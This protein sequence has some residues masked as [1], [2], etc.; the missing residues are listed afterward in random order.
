[1]SEEA[2]ISIGIVGLSE[3]EVEEG[4]V[5]RGLSI[6]TT[7]GIVKTLIHHDPQEPTSKA[8]V[9]VCGASGGLDGPADYMYKLLG[10]ELSPKI[11]SLRV[12]YRYPG[13]LTESVMDTLA[14][15][16]FLTGTGH[17]DILLVGHSFGGAVVI[18][19]APFSEQVKGVIALSSQTAGSH[20][21]GDV[22]PRPLLLIH[23]D[24]D[25]VLAHSCSEMIYDWAEEPKELVL[26]PATGH[27][28][29]ET[30]RDVR[31]KVKSWIENH[32]I[33][34]G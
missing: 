19:A 16:S 18:S 27:R 14:A 6:K 31:F 28:L 17:D 30:S 21:V 22:S 24:E 8:V 4:Q 10:D 25:S 12:D 13:D 5:G 33:D 1:M 7:R 26:M 34:V 3:W 15:V 29:T 9:W 23:G 11:T 20:N 32:L 2:E